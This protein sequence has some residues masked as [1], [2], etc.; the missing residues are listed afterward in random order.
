MVVIE[1]GEVEGEIGVVPIIEDHV[2]IILVMKIT[3]INVVKILI[4]YC[5]YL[6]K[7]RYQRHLV[8]LLVI[9]LVLVF[10]THIANMLILSINIMLTCPLH[11]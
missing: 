8:C 5:K 3:I 9:I 11:L 10:S 6:I 1:L 4:T 7:D 2:D